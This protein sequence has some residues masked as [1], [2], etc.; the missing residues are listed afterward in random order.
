V[1]PAD[2]FEPPTL[3]SEDRCSNP[4]SYAGVM[5]QD[6]RFFSSL[7][8]KAEP[9][10]QARCSFSLNSVLSTGVIISQTFVTDAVY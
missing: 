7:V 9:K 4:L 10:G 3:C 6:L 1:V 8:G 2:G 5:R